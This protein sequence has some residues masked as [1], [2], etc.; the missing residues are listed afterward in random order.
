MRAASGA[1][2]LVGHSVVIARVQE[3]VRRSAALDTGVLLVAG[4]GVDVE[5]IARELHLRGR[6]VAAPFVS[7]ACG[8]ALVDRALFGDPAGPTTT[9]LV[10]V[11]PDSRIAAACGGTL[12]LHEIA[13]LPAAVQARLARVAR[14]GEV[15]MGGE[16]VAT[17]MRLVASAAPGI[18]AEVQQH[19]LRADLF[20]RVSV[21]R[22]DLPALRERADDVPAIA[23]R[24]VE[25][26]C[27]AEG[28]ALRTFTQ[29]ALALVASVAWP[30]NLAELREVIERVIAATPEE[31]IQIEHLLPALQ[32]DRSSLPFS[33]AGTLREARLRFEREYIAAV[34]QHH[35]WR[36]GDA[37]ET[38]G[39]QRPNLYRK[40]R[41][42]GIPLTRVSE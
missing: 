19:R 17:A 14:D 29:T 16:P 1:I 40:A 33:P 32:L 39:I 15:W 24:V 34:L 30:G 21:S 9:D 10:A 4:P 20:R 26:Y 23:A 12:F 28:L 27:A 11:S 25:L 6:S 37:A 31:T 38:L 2:E 42:L 8:S 41:Q 5:S 35:E 36:M 7:V 18:D 13:D 22:I 3:L